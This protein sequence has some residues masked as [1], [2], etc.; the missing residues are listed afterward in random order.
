MKVV[1][2]ELESFASELTLFTRLCSCDAAA[3]VGIETRD[4]SEYTSVVGLMVAGL[5][6]HD[7]DESTW[8][9]KYRLS[10]V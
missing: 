3:K 2:R 5:Q 7:L 10:L 4:R 8:K 1:E 6:V 9:L